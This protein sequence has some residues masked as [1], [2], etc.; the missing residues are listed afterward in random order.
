MS[1]LF[2]RSKIF[3][4]LTL[5]LTAFVFTACSTNEEGGMGTLK[6][7]LTDAPANYE[8]VNI[9]VLQVLVNKD[10]EADDTTGNGWEAIM[11]DSMVVNLLDYQNGAILELGEIELEAGRYNQIRLLLGNDNNVV[12]DGETI[13]L[14][15]PSAQQSGYKLNVQ[16]DVEAGQVFELVIDFDASRSIVQT[17]NGGYILKPVLRTVNTYRNK[18]AF[19][20]PCFL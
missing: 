9:E 1:S 7:S 13:P 2:K 18:A 17:G 20:E 5:L 3:S 11:S 8:Q 15:T 16:A 12:V 6:V 4:F 10:G 14:K 19:P